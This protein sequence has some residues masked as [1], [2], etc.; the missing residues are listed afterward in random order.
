MVCGRVADRT[1]S[2]NSTGKN[3]IAT[4]TAYSGANFCGVNYLCTISTKLPYIPI[5][6]KVAPQSH[7]NISTQG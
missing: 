2:V 7:I 3:E 4:Y 6:L 1:V 5:S